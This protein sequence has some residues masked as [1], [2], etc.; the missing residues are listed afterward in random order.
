MSDSL[1][2][3]VIPVFNR[4]E[5]V[6]AAIQ[7]VLKQSYRHFEIIVVDD[8][9][10]DN[11]KDVV[12]SYG[13]A[14]RYV[15]IDNSGPSV[16]RNVGIRIAKGDYIAFL[17]S[18]DLWDSQKLKVQ[19]K[20]FENDKALGAL[21]TN[22]RYI[23]SEGS[24][25]K[26]SMAG[27]DY[28]FSGNFLLEVSAYRFPHA[29][30]TILLRKIV[31]ENCG[32]FNESLRLA[33]DID[34][35]VRIALKYKVGYINEV[36]ASIRVHQVSLMQ[37]STVGLLR[38]QAMHVLE[39]Y[40]KDLASHIDNFDYYI[41]QSLDFIGNDVLLQGARR[42]AF[43]YYLQALRLTPICLKRYKDLIR[44]LLPLS[45]L[46]TRYEKSLKVEIHENLRRYS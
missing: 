2:S 15:Y 42:D 22:A 32:I 1:V 11:T 38:K 27:K 8:G 26:E 31:L 24:I 16:A 43:V 41:A 23:N 10:T 18:D 5:F 34:L 20:E 7:S 19:M 6:G 35:W 21:F 25:I 4:E 17:D 37:Q 33:E 9:S 46:K 36:L 45:Y 12:S 44:C 28:V 29:S 3:V 13:D 39:R 40:R 14:V 30:D